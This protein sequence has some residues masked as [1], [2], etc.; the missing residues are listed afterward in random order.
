MRSSILDILIKAD[1]Y[2]S[3]T[4]I[5]KVLHVS[6]AAVW[7][8]IKSLREE[9][10]EIESVSS[11]G[12]KLLHYEKKFNKYELERVVRSLSLPLKVYHFETIDSTNTYAKMLKDDG[13]I[14]IA[15]EQTNGRGRLGRVWSSN[16]G[17]G[18]YFSLMFRP[19]IT[20][21]IV[22]MITQITAV[23]LRRTL[24]EGVSIK[25]PNDLFVGDKKLAGV[26]TELVTEINMV[27]R[28]VIGVGL[29]LKKVTEFEDVATSLEEHQ[30]SFNPF[31]F[32]TLFLENFF[33]LYN[34]F[35]E[36]RNLSFLREEIEKYSYFMN[37]EVYIVGSNKECIFRGVTD[38]GNAML[39]GSNGDMEEVYFGEISLRRR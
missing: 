35:F 11:K 32:F 13:A 12:Y 8:H 15:D 7:K 24:G 37:K 34:V 1:D 23:A 30:I 5:S 18:L 19:K 9:G 2:V 26:L 33:K 29:N 16:K 4:E 10:Y 38:Y 6:R 39:E 31:D 17:D 27:E 14:V 3:G 28:V 25:W 36:E 20:P 22:G 21:N